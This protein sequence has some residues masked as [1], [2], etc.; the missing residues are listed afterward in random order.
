MP[1]KDKTAAELLSPRQKIINL[2]PVFVTNQEVND[3]INIVEYPLY[4]LIIIELLIIA[5]LLYF[6][7]VITSSLL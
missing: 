5:F 3:S 1:T 4:L 2:N 7:F 6:F